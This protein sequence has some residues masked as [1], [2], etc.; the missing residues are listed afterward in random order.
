MKFEKELKKFEDLMVLKGFTAKTKKNY[1]YCISKYFEFLEKTSFSID[2]VSANE[3][4]L[5]LNRKKLVA[6]SIRIYVASVLFLFKDVLR[7]KVDNFD[8]YLPRKPKLLPKVLSKEEV[9]KIIE[10]IENKKHKLIVSVL[11]SSGI[12]LS[13][14]INLKRN[15]I[16]T[17]RNIILIRNGKGQKDRITILSKKVKSQLIDYLIETEFETKYLFETNR[18]SKYTGKSIQLILKKASKCINK[19][20]TPHML[21]HPFATHLLEAG[22]DIRYIQKLL[23]HANLETTSIY[24]N[25]AANKLEDIKSPF[26]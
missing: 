20:V 18:R 15:D 25:V 8:I 5:F 3:Y 24:T 19:N 1:N 6:N 17:D 16:Q 22:T 12:R 23:G 10:N 7:M 26:D 9:F 13:E 21:R 11:Y 4:F 2:I 14:V